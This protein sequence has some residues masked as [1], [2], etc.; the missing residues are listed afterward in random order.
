MDVVSTTPLPG[1]GVPINEIPSNVQSVK[2]EALR[3]QQSLGIAR[4]RSVAP[5]F[6]EVKVRVAR[7]IAAPEAS[8]TTP[9]RPPL[10]EPCAHIWPG[11]T[12]ANHSASISKT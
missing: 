1:L 10:I 6:S 12:Q 3:D 4:F 9:R 5:V 8:V 2:G 11:S 7:G